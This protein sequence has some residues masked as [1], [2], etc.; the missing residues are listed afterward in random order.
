MCRGGSFGPPFGQSPEKR[1]HRT[2]RLSFRA[3]GCAMMGPGTDRRLNASMPRGGSSRVSA[4]CTDR[5][6]LRK[7][8]APS[9]YPR[10]RPT[11]LTR[12]S[13]GRIA[14]SAANSSMRCAPVSPSCGNGFSA[15][16]AAASGPRMTS[17]SLGVRRNSSTP[18][19]SACRRCSAMAPR[20][21]RF[22]FQLLGR[23]PHRVRRERANALQR[24]Q[25]RV[26]LRG[27]ECTDSTSQTNKVNGSRGGG[28]NAP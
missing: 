12:A 24:R 20:A 11:R 25:R 4:C 13:T 15:R 6:F 18:V 7:S 27:V 23:P 8:P 19:R 26:A 22:V 10:R 14:W 1:A 21:S 2:V 28:G 9:P 16:R 3:G 17:G 5:A